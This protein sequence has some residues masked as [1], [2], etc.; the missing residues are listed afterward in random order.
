MH[1]LPRSSGGHASGA[2]PAF[3][4]FYAGEFPG[5]VRRASLL[6]GD[7]E[8]AH[9]VV[10]DAFVAVYRR[11]G[12]LGDP[13]PYLNRVVLNGCR[14]TG[15]RRSRSERLL[16]RLVSRRADDGGAVDLLDD[17]L[18]ALPFNQR[19]AVVLRYWGGLT[20]AE[21]AAQLECSPGSVGPWI[22]RALTRMRREL[23]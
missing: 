17:V 5:Q 18:A 7:P 21:I 2:P 10:Q 9:D 1:I 22:N 11:W 14:D 20:E 4:D 8:L 16:A 13:G 6:L 15:R 3:H 19:A 12:E 23:A